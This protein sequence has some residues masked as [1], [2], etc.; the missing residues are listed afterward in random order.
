MDGGVASSLLRNKKNKK[1]DRGRRVT[2][3]NQNGEAAMTIGKTP[4][5]AYDNAYQY[6]KTSVTFWLE[7]WFIVSGDHTPLAGASVGMGGKAPT[8]REKS[9][10]K[11]FESL[12]RPTGATVQTPRVRPSGVR[13]PVQPEKSG[14]RV[15]GHWR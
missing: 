14:T 5:V 11:V 1:T 6:K 15:P 9:D 8:P 2:N 3:S 10:T 12:E 13:T 7:C 4:R